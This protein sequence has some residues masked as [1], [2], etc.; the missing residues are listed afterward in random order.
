MTVPVLGCPSLEASY[1]SLA[2][3]S[4]AQ[5]QAGGSEGGRDCT[6]ARRIGSVSLVA[7]GPKDFPLS[8][9]RGT[10]LSVKE[11]TVPETRGHLPTIAQSKECHDFLLPL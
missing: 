2:N 1:L 8:P 5:G 11:D 9:S 7:H 4:S 3:W 6:P 10:P